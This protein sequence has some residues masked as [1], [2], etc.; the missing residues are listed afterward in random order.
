MS[1]QLILIDTV[2]TAEGF[3]SVCPMAAGPTEALQS[4]ENYVV[5]LEGGVR[6]AD[7]TAKVGAVS[8]AATFTVASTGS[9]AA[10]AGTLLNVTLTG[11]ASAPA[12]NEFVVSTTPSIQ[13]TNMAAA[14]NASTS[15]N[16]KVTAVA[17]GAVV[18]I[19]SK[20]PGVM[21]NG[22]QIAAG[23][24]ANVTA[25]AFASGSDGTEYRLSGK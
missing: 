19:T 1:K 3:K 25:G 17:V 10:Q 12:T 6:S 5:S 24:L 23:T 14:I 20:I 11:R 21:S 22:L 4:L 7:V 2:L 18:T 13:A 8:A 15:L 16:T 9:V